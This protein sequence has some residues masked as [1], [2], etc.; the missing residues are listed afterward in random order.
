MHFDA[1]LAPRRTLLLS[2]RKECHAY[3]SIQWS[4]TQ[5][6]V[7]NTAGWLL[8][9]RCSTAHRQA[10]RTHA[11]SDHTSTHTSSRPS[12]SPPGLIVTAAHSDEREDPG[13][14]EKHG[15]DGGHGSDIVDVFLC[16]IR[17]ALGVA[18]IPLHR[19]RV[20]IPIIRGYLQVIRLGAVVA[21]PGRRDNEEH[22]GDEHEGVVR[23]LVYARA[24]GTRVGERVAHGHDD[25]HHH[26]GDGEDR[27]AALHRGGGVCDFEVQ[28]SMV[29]WG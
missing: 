16:L 9:F 26:H 10:T 5:N 8:S 27:V 25:Q 14:R 24:I 17:E 7:Q 18:V 6:A 4:L 23:K 13:K 22:G 11:H 28:V 20:G 29:R 2:Q 15:H 1:S 19:I 12:S 21:A 3:A